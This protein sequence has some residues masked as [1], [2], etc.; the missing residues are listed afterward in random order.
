MLASFNP[1][2]AALTVRAT[3]GR[4]RALLFAVPCCCR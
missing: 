2:V 1:T 3:L 4:R